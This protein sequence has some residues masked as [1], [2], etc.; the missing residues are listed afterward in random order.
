M[1]FQWIETVLTMVKHLGIICLLAVV[2]C[3]AGCQTFSKSD[4]GWGSSKEMWGTMGKKSEEIV[5]GD[6]QKLAVLWTDTTMIGPD[7]KSIRGFA[8]RVYFNDKQN[9]PVRVE[10]ELV[11]YAYD[12]SSSATKTTADRVYKFREDELQSHYGPSGIGPVVQLLD[13]LG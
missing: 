4:V 11:V 7:G 1:A 3:H 2:V 12:D 10:G 5:Y 13:P 6:A 9:K 8:G